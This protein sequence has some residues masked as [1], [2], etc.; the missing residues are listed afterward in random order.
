MPRPF[1]QHPWQ[2]LR[3][4]LACVLLAMT[5]ASVLAQDGEA[6]SE[7]EDP[8]RETDISEDNYRRYMEL[9]D[10]R[11]ERPAFPAA[12]IQPRSS[13]EKMGQL[14]EESQ[15]HLR[16]ELRGII[17][18]RGPWT[19]EERDRPYGF[20]PSAAAQRDPALLRQEAE[21]WGELVSEYHDREAAIL[22]GREA[23]LSGAPP[24][25][26]GEPGQPT[27][28]DPSSGT[29]QPA[30]AQGANAGDQASARPGQGP[31]PNAGPGG[32]AGGEGGEPGEDGEA[33]SR[34]ETGNDA[35]GDGARTAGA[36]ERNPGARTRVPGEWQEPPAP[37]PSAISD[38]GVAQSASDFLR[39]Q[40]MSVKGADPA[41][42]PPTVALPG[43]S[44]S[45]P[46]PDE[47]G[48]GR[49]GDAALTLP[50]PVESA[51]EPR[52]TPGDA[53]S[54]AGP[55]P[56]GG[57]LTLDELRG[58]RGV[59]PVDDTGEPGQDPDESDEATDDEK[60]AMTGDEA[61][62]E[63]AGDASDDDSGVG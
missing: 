19:P 28:T 11:L 56:P 60:D 15:K 48:N 50:P 30:T 39:R 46:G 59:A 54:V 12:A 51:P 3:A 43:A 41:A 31:N 58:V 27:G 29:G 7:D 63:E 6:P 61:D 52:A 13:L 42:N 36:E 8:S 32:N 1:P 9:D 25:G 2:T 49:W 17:L 5:P 23:R 14:P 35:A 47:T 40:G 10:R 24:P 62:S 20:V 16:N 53:A 45:N 26:V 44:T 55:P 18:A 21:A 57:V 37:A 22:A 33:D 4:I 34:G 38:E